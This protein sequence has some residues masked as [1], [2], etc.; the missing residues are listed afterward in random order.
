VGWV[1]DLVWCGNQEQRGT[2]RCRK[3]RKSASL[4]LPGVTSLTASL[5]AISAR[6]SSGNLS[7]CLEV[8]FIRHP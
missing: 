4:Y 3:E 8:L 6:F 7:T 1:R 2:D 5:N